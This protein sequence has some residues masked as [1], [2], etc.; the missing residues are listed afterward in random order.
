MKS[1]ISVFVLILCL[2]KPVFGICIEKSVEQKTAVADVVFV[3]KITSWEYM[4]TNLRNEIVTTRAMILVDSVRKGE[5]KKGQ[6]LFVYALYRRNS[7]ENLSWL[8]LVGKQV[9]IYTN[10]KTAEELRGQPLR[11]IEPGTRVLV[12]GSC[13]VDE[14]VQMPG[15]QGIQK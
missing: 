9:V 3:G 13:L 7:E 6:R 5:I 10:L 15:L 12:T 1:G 4:E 8:P 11:G 2:A 14:L